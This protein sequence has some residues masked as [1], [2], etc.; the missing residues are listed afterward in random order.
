MWANKNWSNDL[1]TYDIIDS[2]LITDSDHNIVLSTFNTSNTIRNNRISI[3]KKKKI[4][5]RFYQ[6]D[7]A[8]KENWDRYREVMD[9]A[10][11][12]FAK[13]ITQIVF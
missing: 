1:F 13:R 11:T 12:D 9:K 4:T 5:R 6:Y 3:Q 2:E 10:L 7:K 8:T